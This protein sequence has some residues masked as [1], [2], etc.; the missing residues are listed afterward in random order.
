[1]RSCWTFLTLCCGVHQNHRSTLTREGGIGLATAHKAV[2]KQLKL[3]K[4]QW[5][6][7]VTVQ[8]STI[9][10]AYLRETKSPNPG[11]NKM[12][13]LRTAN[14]SIWN[15]WKRFLENVSSLQTYG[16]LARRI[17][18]HQS[19]KIYMYRDG[20]CTLNDFKTAIRSVSEAD[21]QK[22]FAN[23]IKR[24]QACINTRGYHFQYLLLVHS[25]FPNTLYSK[26]G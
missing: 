17:S 3:L 14:N 22:A 5:T 10:W 15:S 2:R 6:V 4:K 21:L 26:Y 13:L 20:P 19:S 12:T 1:M 16:P 25:D 23:R 18:L 9:S 11:F 24:V 8:F 7:N